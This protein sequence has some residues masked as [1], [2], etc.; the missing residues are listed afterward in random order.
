MRHQKFRI[1]WLGL[2]LFAF[3]ENVEAGV[4]NLAPKAKVSASSEYDGRY[5]AKFAVDGN[6]PGSECKQDNGQA[7]CIHRQKVGDKGTTWAD[8]PE[9]HSSGQPVSPYTSW[10]STANGSES[11]IR[12][13]KPH[14]WGSPASKVADIILAGHPDKDGKPQIEM[15]DAER[16]RVFAWIDLNIPYY[17]EAATNYPKRMGCRRMLPPDLGQVLQEVAMRRCTSCHEGGEIPRTFYTRVTRI[18][19]N[20]FL[21]APLAKSAGGTEVCGK[22]TFASKDDPDYQKILAVFKPIQEM[23]KE[24]PRMDMP[25]ARLTC[26]TCN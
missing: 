17:G 6:V 23:L 9:Q 4:E 15:T 11:N 16:L 22:P 26:D 14:R 21:L 3:C 7:W 25:G 2:V 13:I 12:E 20:D 5:L 8:H 10:I 1:A 19:D 24:R 18:E